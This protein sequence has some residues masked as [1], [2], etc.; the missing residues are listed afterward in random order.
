MLT[1]S[2][3]LTKKSAVFLS[4]SLISTTTT[5]E[6]G[7]ADE[8]IMVMEKRAHHMFSM[9]KMTIPGTMMARDTPDGIQIT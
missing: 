7:D 4:I 5:I 1:V 6:G 3:S 2:V 8:I 9:I